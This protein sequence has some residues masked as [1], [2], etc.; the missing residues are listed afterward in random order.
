[1][2]THG[3]QLGARAGISAQLNC[4]TELL[5]NMV[6]AGHGDRTAFF[7]PGGR[8]TYRDVL[9]MSNRIAHVLVEDLAS[10]PAIASCFAARTR[11]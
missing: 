6:Q 8:W 1:M 4:A 7:F 2:A 9:E 5:D 3:F 10:S 11:R